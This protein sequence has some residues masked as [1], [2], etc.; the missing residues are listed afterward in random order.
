MGVSISQNCGILPTITQFVGHIILHIIIVGND[1]S[2]QVW[3]VP[4]V[5]PCITI[6][7]RL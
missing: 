7:V 6:A 3:C 2:C 5:K 1:I 4:T